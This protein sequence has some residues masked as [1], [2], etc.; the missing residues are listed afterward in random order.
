MPAD[1]ARPLPEVTARETAAPPRPSVAPTAGPRQKRRRVLWIGAAL[2]VLAAAGGAGL[3]WRTHHGAQ[4]TY[5]TARLE[6]GPVARAVTASGTVNPVLTV[7][8]G[9]YVSGVIQD[10]ACDY[11][12]P[13]HKGQV[14]ARIDPRP[15]Q[16]A[17]DQAAAALG[18][19]RAQLVKDRAVLR[20]AEA[21][22]GRNVRLEGQ[23]WMA[24]DAAENQRSVRDAATAQISVDEAEVAQREAAL[25]A[26]Q[27][28]LGYTRIVS[29]V[30][31]VVVSRNVTQG[32]TVAASFQTPTLFLIAQ[33]LTKMQVDTNVSEG[34]IE[35]E[36]R[37][38]RVGD[39]ATFTVEAFP[40]RPFTGRVSQIRQAP[41]TVQNVV[42]Y[43][44]VI[45]VDNAKLR[46]KPGMTATVRI[47]T[48]Q[49]ANVLRAPN[50]ALRY[51]P[52]GLHPAGQAGRAGQGGQ[53]GEA[54]VA[55]GD[56]LFV[57]RDGKPSAT[58][59][60]VGLADDSFTEIASGAVAAGDPVVIGETGA[61][62]AR[63]GNGAPPPRF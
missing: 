50:A 2:A 43:D 33:D 60:R 19:A 12:T 20:Y 57:L 24:H 17:V 40:G 45:A 30:D 8:V 34:D 37:G 44:V 32:Q 13:V 35:G 16:M 46:L 21:K 42:T 15:Y 14:C 23:G 51:T 3:Y 10:I 52:G 25:R 18:V 26:A 31:G 59:V 5:T 6:R 58:P 9:T 39:A 36:G 49:R 61:P 22:Y 29:P 28:N 1:A 63:R 11:N 41:Q 55:H 56:R 62:G 27:V 4:A 7:I 53:G 38:I 48:D 47:V 54:R